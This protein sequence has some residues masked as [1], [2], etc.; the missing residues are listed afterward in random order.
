[1]VLLLKRPRR[2]G[3][4]RYFRPSPS[5]FA[6]A[7]AFLSRLAVPVSVPAAP[8]PPLQIGA[9]N[10]PYAHP[11]PD[12]P[13]PAAAATAPIPCRPPSGSRRT[14]SAPSPNSPTPSPSTLYAVSY[15]FSAKPRLLTAAVYPVQKK[16]LRAVLAAGLHGPAGGRARAMRRFALGSCRA[17]TV[18]Q[19]AMPPPLR[20]EPVV[21]S[22]AASPS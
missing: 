18:S 11:A 7:R 8:R 16:L 19:A 20:R 6:R 9:H 22:L 17:L 10:I 5:P 4:A 12:P 3:P 1:M 21:P 15:P 2:G 14:L 13:A